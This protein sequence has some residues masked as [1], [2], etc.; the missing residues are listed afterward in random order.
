MGIVHIHQ[1]EIGSMRNFV[2]L[3]EAGGEAIVVDPQPDTAPW[4][5][6]LLKQGLKLKAILLTHTHHD[7]VGGIANVLSKYDVPI[8]VHAGDVF[9]LKPDLQKHVKPIEEGEKIS[10]GNAFIDVLHTPGHSAGECCYLVNP[11]SPALLTGDTIFVGN[12]GRTDLPTG[13]DAELFKT[14]QRIKALPMHTVLYP[15]HNYGSTTTTTI[16]RECRESLAFKCK[17]AEEL[18]AIP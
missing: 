14:L 13:D 2:Y 3:L 17:S 12:V 1:F 6:P 9:R 5:K 8:Y 7:H 18:A 15:G 16:E 10:L 4:E 11:T